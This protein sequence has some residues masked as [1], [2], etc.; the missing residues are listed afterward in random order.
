MTIRKKM[1]AWYSIF[2]LVLMI[3]LALIIFFTVRCFLYKDAENTM[4][5]NAA[6]LLAAIEIE[7]NNV[8]L[9]DHTAASDCN[10]TV[11]TASG[12]IFYDNTGWENLNYEPTKW[13][14]IAEIT[15][16]GEDF[17][18]LDTQI[19]DENMVVGHLRVILSTNLIERTMSSISI[20][21]ILFISVSII[22]VVMGSLS[23]AGAALK[24]IDR[25]TQTAQQIS[26]L[27]LSKRIDVRET[28]D[29]IGRLIKTF[30][31]MLVNLESAFIRE[32]QFSSDASH[33]LRTPLSV[34]TV[35]AEEA[36]HG[37][38]TIAEYREAL[39]QIVFE[40]KKMNKII[41]QLLTLTRGYE[42][43]LAVSKEKFNL[44]T[45][46]YDVVNEMKDFADSFGVTVYY[47]QQDITIYADHMLITQMLI[48]LINNA[49]KYGKPGGVVTITTAVAESNIT[50]TVE[51]NGI[52]ISEA[53]LSHIFERFYRADKS[54]SGDGSGL[55][56]SIVQWIAAAHSGNVLVTSMLG[57]GTSIKINIPYQI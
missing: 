54:H 5:T 50:I 24:P 33:E 57:K 6:K 8:M 51:D 29:E 2:F 39:E 3:L 9:I 27:D 22:I 55:G 14:E 26:Q 34:I 43:K 31:E 30:N 41:T 4:Q 1:A 16:D 7:D 49:C 47:E 32:K 13:D 18:L 53:D 40:S 19:K 20:L 42:N 23:I 11:F 56:L 28:D 45:V 36:L 12:E 46:I 15:I 17:L 38:K 44:R 48:N 52:G 35:H 21:F 10:F 25:V 37:E